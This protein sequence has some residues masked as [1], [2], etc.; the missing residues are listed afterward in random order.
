MNYKIRHWYGTQ[1]PISEAVKVGEHNTCYANGTPTGEI[2]NDYEVEINDL[3]EFAKKHGQIKLV[4]PT[5]PDE[6]WLIWVTRGNRWGQ[7]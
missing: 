1:P 5:S 6:K 3:H 2:C 7:C 4:P